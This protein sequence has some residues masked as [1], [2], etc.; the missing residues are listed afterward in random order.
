MIG[1]NN[2]NNNTFVM[3][4]RQRMPKLWQELRAGVQAD[5]DLREPLAVLL[6]A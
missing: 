2:I 4:V 6:T 3:Q 5:D 1:V